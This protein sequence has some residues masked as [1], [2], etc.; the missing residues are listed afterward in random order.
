MRQS[1]AG[2]TSL[3]AETFYEMATAYKFDY[4]LGWRQRFIFL[5]RFPDRRSPELILSATHVDV[6]WQMGSA[7]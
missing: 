6:V 3:R 2:I 7:A 5:V 1:L 4:P